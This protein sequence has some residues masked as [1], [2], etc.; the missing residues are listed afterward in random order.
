VRLEAP[1]AGEELV[2]RHLVQDCLLVVDLVLVV[3]VMAVRLV[4]PLVVPC[5]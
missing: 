4:V 3:V 1:V 2:V 5:P